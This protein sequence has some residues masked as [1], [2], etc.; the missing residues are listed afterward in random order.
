MTDPLLIKTVVHAW[1]GV[2]LDDADAAGAALAL[3]RS[4]DALKA[5]GAGELGFDHDKGLFQAQLVRAGE[6]P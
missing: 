4:L 2:T 3:D 5:A 6:T 1:H